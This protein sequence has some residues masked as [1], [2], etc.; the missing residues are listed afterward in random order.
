MYPSAKD[1]A[2]AEC[3]P[4]IVH[5]ENVVHQAIDWIMGQLDS[6]DSCLCSF[7][8]TFDLFYD[9]VQLLLYFFTGRSWSPW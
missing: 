8:L 1:I 5:A 6:P 7:K 9:Y 4:E 2:S 3:T